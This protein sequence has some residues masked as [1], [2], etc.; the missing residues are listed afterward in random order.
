MK[1]R[2]TLVC[3]FRQTILCSDK[4]PASSVRQ[5]FIKLPL[6]QGRD[7]NFTGAKW[8]S[9]GMRLTVD[10]VGMDACACVLCACIYLY[11]SAYICLCV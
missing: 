1:E 5:A 10:C 2:Q 8:V 6:Q 9:D 3:N 4:Y 11:L 7:L